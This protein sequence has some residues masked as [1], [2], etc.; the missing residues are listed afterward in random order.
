MTWP[1]TLSATPLCRI[2]SGGARGEHF[3]CLLVTYF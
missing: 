3:A 1:I 2:A